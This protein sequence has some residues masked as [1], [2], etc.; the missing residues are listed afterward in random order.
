MGTEQCSCSRYLFPWFKCLDPSGFDWVTLKQKLHQKTPSLD[1]AFAMIV[2]WAGKDTHDGIWLLWLIHIIGQIGFV[3]QCYQTPWCNNDLAG[4]M[5]QR[6]SARLLRG[7]AWRQCPELDVH[8]HRFAALGAVCQKW[9]WQ[10]GGS[11]ND[12]CAGSGVRVHKWLCYLE[13]DY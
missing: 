5:P 3:Q 7:Q 6:I 13:W 8:L 10:G 1:P 2:C 12:G 11:N 4:A 9:H